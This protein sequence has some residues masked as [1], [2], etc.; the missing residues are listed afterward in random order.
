MAKDEGGIE[1]LLDFNQLKEIIS[2]ALEMTHSQ[3]E[4]KLNCTRVGKRFRISLSDVKVISKAGGF[5]GEKAQAS[6]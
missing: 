4:I 1:I 3:S 6:C 5:V 2:E